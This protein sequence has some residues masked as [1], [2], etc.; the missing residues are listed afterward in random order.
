MPASLGAAALV[1][2]YQERI[3]ALALGLTGNH[4][5]AVDLSQEAL[6][7][8]W[9]NLDAYRGG[10]KPLTRFYRI[11]RKHLLEPDAREDTASHDAAGRL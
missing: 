1:K 4:H 9:E 6:L 3:Y 7:K 8:A 10:A 11:H 2:R 5:D